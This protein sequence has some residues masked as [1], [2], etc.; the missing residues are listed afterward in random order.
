MD[1]GNEKKERNRRNNAAHPRARDSLVLSPS[2]S[3]HNAVTSEKKFH[4]LT[5]G[6]WQRSFS[7]LFPTALGQDRDE[8]ETIAKYGGDT[9][10]FNYLQISSNDFRNC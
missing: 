9:V 1:A 10:V 8:Q 6:W 4:W 7:M 3:F 5:A 2:R